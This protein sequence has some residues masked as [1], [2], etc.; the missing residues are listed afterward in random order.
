[1]W[2]G[3]T[4][5]FWTDRWIQGQSIAVFAPY[6]ISRIPRRV[7][8]GRTVQEAL[9]DNSWVH[10]I[11]GSLAA[12]VI[13]EFLLVW[14]LI[15]DVHLQTGV[16]DVHLW[17]PCASDLYSSKTAYNSFWT[18][19]TSF[20]PAKRIWKSWAPPKCKFFIG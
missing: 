5:L 18:G 6:L 19:T 12:V 3:A 7:R 8:T 16:P 10:D 15:Q 2:D 17:V 11:S 13:R 1:V 9:V 4:T 14:D 20:E